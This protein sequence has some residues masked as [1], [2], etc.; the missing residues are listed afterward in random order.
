MSD[1]LTIALPFFMLIFAGMGAGKLGLLSSANMVGF[2]N[3][4][5][6][7]ALPGLLFDKLLVAPLSGGFDLGVIL[8]YSG[9]GLIVYA[10]GFF[11]SRRAFGL[12]ADEAAIQGMGGAF[13]NIGYMGLPIIIALFGEKAVLPAVAIL[14]MDNL[15]LIAL[16]TALIEGSRGGGHVAAAI[17]RALKGVARNPLILA[18][19]AGLICNVFDLPVPGLVRQFASILGQAAAPCALF[20][21][22][23]SLAER[24]LGRDWGQTGLMTA[25]KVLFHPFLA[26]VIAFPLL[27]LDPLLGA[28]AVIEAS[29]P[30]AANVFIQARAYNVY[31]GPTSAAVLLSTLL[32]TLTVPLLMGLFASP[33]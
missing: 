19:A 25:N 32:A 27:G 15:L 13:G 16:T 33:L 1:I 12:R 7:F 22:G 4:I 3:F 23:A 31:M 30:I 2:N 6:W 5:F 28:V 11:L 20:A 26:W 10:L 24:G 18:T 17:M 21:L 29:L 14:V 8:A 9:A